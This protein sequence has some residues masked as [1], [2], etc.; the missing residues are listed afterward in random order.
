MDPNPN[1]FPILS[2][3]MSKVPSFRR[4]AGLVTDEHDIEQPSSSTAEVSTP[5]EPHFE[6]TEQMPHLKNPE[7]F[8]AMRLAVADV[9][10][11]RSVLKTL[12][13]RPDH[14]SV[15]RAKA[16]LAEIEANISGQMD[17]I[18]LSPKKGG[19]EEEEA[20]G[21]KALEREKE[22]CKSVISL[23]EMHE[24]YENML[25]GAEERLQK[26]YDAAVAGSHGVEMEEEKKEVVV[27]EVDEEVVALLKDVEANKIIEKVNLSARKLRLVPEAFGKIKSMVV[28]DL[29]SNQIEVRYYTFTAMLLYFTGSFCFV[30]VSGSDL[31]Y[32][33][34]IILP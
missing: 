17:E 6:L 25:R 8:S 27:E 22:L 16:K 15:D 23:D 28:L 21:W 20:G 13:E 5:K 33:N 9:A 30:H 34:F 1:N 11:S 26:I 3:V 10:Q 31:I 24:T 29:S 32:Y 4:A 14:E 12:G 7:I 18:V 2:Y 19:K